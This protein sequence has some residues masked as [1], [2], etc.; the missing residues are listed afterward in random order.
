M[1]VLRLT[2]YSTYQL[3]SPRLDDN[4]RPYELETWREHELRMNPTTS[5]LVLQSV[6]G[7][8]GPVGRPG[9]CSY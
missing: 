5:D 4:P 2:G 9:N 8:L 7:Q 6:E 1:T 3:S